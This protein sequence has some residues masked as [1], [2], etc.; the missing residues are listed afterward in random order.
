[1]IDEAP[2]PPRCCCWFIFLVALFAGGCTPSP[3]AP[4]L[5]NGPVY[6]DTREGF[7]FNAPE[8]WKQRARAIVPAGKIKKEKL[9]VEYK[10]ANTELGG[11]FQVTVADVPE[12][13]SL[14]DYLAKNTRTGESWRLVQP[15]E[16]FTINEASAARIS[17]SKL[18]GKEEFMREVVAFRRGERVYFFKCYYARRDAASRRALRGCVETIVW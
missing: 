12:T 9:L 16:D 14:S 4:A 1:M 11:D 13:A 3:S 8:G 2:I 10:N 17:Y 5:E 7:R 15:A 18:V 6:H